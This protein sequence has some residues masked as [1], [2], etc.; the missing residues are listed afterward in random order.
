[1]HDWITQAMMTD[2]K[3]SI[4]YR[5]KSLKMGEGLT[6]KRNRVST[7]RR[8]HGT[9]GEGDDGGQMGSQNL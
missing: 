9:S 3:P 2:L 7:V 8:R 1:M 4:E 5:R 6:G